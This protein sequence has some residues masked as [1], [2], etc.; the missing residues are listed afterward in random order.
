M[1]ALA[2][3]YVG[4]SLSLLIIS[5]RGSYVLQWQYICNSIFLLDTSRLAILVLGLVN[6]EVQREHLYFANL[7]SF[8]SITTWLQIHPT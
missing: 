1:I 7:L 2:G 4:L 8:E 5:R 3:I 6:N